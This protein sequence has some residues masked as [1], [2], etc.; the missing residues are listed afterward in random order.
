MC[1]IIPFRFKENVKIP[2]GRDPDIPYD[3]PV[4]V[5]DVVFDD[6]VSKAGGS[7]G[8]ECVIQAPERRQCRVLRTDLNRLCEKGLAERVM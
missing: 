4:G 1:K 2:S 6:I 5:Y 8:S 3:I 7:P